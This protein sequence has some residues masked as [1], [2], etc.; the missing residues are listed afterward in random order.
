MGPGPQR[1]TCAAAKR[2]LR[3]HGANE[4]TTK[5]LI[6]HT[7]KLSSCPVLVECNERPK[8]WRVKASPALVVVVVVVV[9]N[10]PPPCGLVHAGP[11]AVLVLRLLFNTTVLFPRAYTHSTLVYT[12]SPPGR[13]GR[14]AGYGAPGRLRPPAPKTPATASTSFPAGPSTTP[15]WR[16]KVWAMAAAPLV[17]SD[18]AMEDADPQVQQGSA[19]GQEAARAAS[20]G[21]VSPTAAPESRSAAVTGGDLVLAAGAARARVPAAQAARLSQD[22]PLP[23]PPR[24]RLRRARRETARRR[25]SCVSHRAGRESCRRWRASCT[26]WRVWP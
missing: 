13:Q 19:G 23:Q 6:R 14:R 4:A 10:V 12:H 26:A 2:S 11:S 21:G 15:R 8:R 1:R 9:H 7:K 22:C 25:T 18:I 20:G 3:W 17:S 24:P 16:A 5:Y